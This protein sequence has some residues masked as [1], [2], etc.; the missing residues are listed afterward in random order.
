MIAVDVF[1]TDPSSIERVLARHGDAL[2]ALLRDPA[3]A[4]VRA[5]TEA[6]R[7]D[8][9]YA[10]VEPST[11]TYYEPQGRISYLTIDIVDQRDV[12]QRMAFSPRPTGTHA[13]PG[14]LI[15]AWQAYE[16]V[17]FGLLK[18][19][20][21]SPPPADCPSF[22]CFGDPRQP[23]LRSLAAE[24]AAGVPAHVDE[25][26]T[27]L[28]DD[29]RHDHRGAAAYLLA[30]A[31]DGRT[32]VADL[33]PA[34][35]DA[36]SLVRNNAMRVLAEIALH[37]PEVDVPV[38]PIIE[39]LGYP[40]TS[41]RNK[42]A[43]TLHRLLGRPGAAALYPRIVR[44]AGQI[45]LAMLRLQQPNNHDYAYKILKTISGRAHGERD[46]AAWQAWLAQAAAE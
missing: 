37:H 8:G 46:H 2:R 26:A 10:Y 32:V 34:L 35:H 42:A 7:A 18:R 29:S 19:G 5:V 30:Y 16:A 15:A 39:A 21:L 13:D 20:A 41:D 25:L 40:A 4:N 11:V 24:M 14:G 36:S 33:V 38:A 43:A 22:H 27:I 28:R 9:G 45:L 1:D 44:D 12:A 31:R 3:D 23:E 6:I 17:A